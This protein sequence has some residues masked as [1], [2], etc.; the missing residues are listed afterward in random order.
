[1]VYDAAAEGELARGDHAATIV[2]AQ[3][4]NTLNVF[5]NKYAVNVLYKDIYIHCRCIVH[6]F[7]EHTQNTQ[8]IQQN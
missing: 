5:V 7:T 1:M 2:C 4:T 3:N 6:E 8:K